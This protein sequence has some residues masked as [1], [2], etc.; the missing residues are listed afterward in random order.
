MRSG[1]IGASV[2]SWISE[3]L[4]EELD[5]EVIRLSSQDVPTAYAKLLEDGAPR[6]AAMPVRACEPLGLTRCVA[7]SHHR[8]SEGRRDRH[9][10]DLRINS[11]RLAPP[12]VVQ[13][14]DVV[15]KHVLY[16]R[17]AR[18]TLQLSHQRRAR[19]VAARH[20]Q[21][22]LRARH[23]LVCNLYAGCTAGVSAEWA[24]RRACQR[25]RTTA[26]TPYRVSALCALSTSSSSSVSSLKD[27]T[28]AL[29]AQEPRKQ[30]VGDG[31]L[32]SAGA[33][34]QRTPRPDMHARG[35]P[36]NFGTG[37]SWSVSPPPS[38]GASCMDGSDWILCSGR[39]LLRNHAAARTHERASA[40]DA[41]CRARTRARKSRTPRRRGRTSR[42]GRT[43]V[44][45]AGIS[46]TARAGTRAH[47][48][49]AAPAAA[50]PR[51]AGAAGSQTPS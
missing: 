20:N 37:W 23:E 25:A 11:Y 33:R 16:V 1:G 48:A 10:E 6:R 28:N 9:Q 44:R 35:A 40:R 17:V 47:A 29:G 12:C 22:A 42:L 43:A 41:A 30:P 8:A 46:A 34:R 13:P 36:R 4:L 27:T 50:P 19:A 2:S 39:R 15:H 3:N 5:H 24:P 21:H 31:T 38:V 7:R 51:G 32:L 49:A 18:G 45:C 26:C 14:R